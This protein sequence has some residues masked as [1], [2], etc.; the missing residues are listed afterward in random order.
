MSKC[1]GEDDLRKRARSH[2][3]ILAVLRA[4]D[5]NPI[6]LQPGVEIMEGAWGGEP[7]VALVSTS[8]PM[9]TRKR[10]EE[11]LRALHDVSIE[12]SFSATLDEVCRRAVEC[13]RDRL[14]IDRLGIWLID[15][16][17]PHWKLGTWGIDD[18]GRI[19]DEHGIKTPREL[20]DFPM[21]YNE[22][23]MPYL[24]QKAFRFH[25]PEGAV[26]GRADRIVAPMWDGRRLVGE[27]SADNL[28]SHKKITNEKAEIVVLFARMV[29]HLASLKQAEEEL[30]RLASVD[31]L[32][33]AVNRRTALII[34]EK[35]SAQCRRT[36]SP[37]SICI[38]DLDGLK[39]VNDR[40][41]HSAGDEYIR[42]A[43]EALVGA[44]RDSDTVGRIGGDEFLVIF[45]DCKSESA[46]SILEKVNREL[47]EKAAALKYLP[48]LSWGVSSLAELG[49]DEALDGC[50]RIDMLLE[51]ADQRM[52]ENKRLRGCPRSARDE[53]EIVF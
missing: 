47:A 44:V 28:I 6:I 14:G 4:A 32:T 36:G 15:N 30:R 21:E 49:E 52:Y 18:K 38:A 34:L 10:Y 19:R 37:L 53:A 42:R 26:L 50:R 1:L 41:G 2:G 45:P 20:G 7:S 43:C 22:G 39:L 48:R 3:K 8:F 11:D 31:P 29:A 46:G 12:L 35:H 25:D 24:C 23:G 27:I 17:D 13:G 5:A 33:G 51:L 16:D 9:A 40:F